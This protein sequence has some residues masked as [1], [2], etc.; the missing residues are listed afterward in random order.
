M[1]ITPLR[2][3]ALACA[4]FAILLVSG[5]KASAI[6]VGI[7]INVGTPP[8]PPVV[9]H[10]WAKPYPDAVWIPGH[11]EWRDGHWVWIGGY[12]AYPPHHGA[13]W[14]PARYHDGRYYAGH[15]D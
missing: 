15:W 2:T 3:T 9:E 8:P 13:H 5:G 11:H 6:G 4:A 7:G 10:P 12:Y 14:E 1:K